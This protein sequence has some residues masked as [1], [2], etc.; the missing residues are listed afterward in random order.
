MNPEERSYFNT[1]IDKLHEEIHKIA[2]KVAE[3][4]Q[5]KKDYDDNIESKFDAKKARRNMIFGIVG[6]ITAVVAIFIALII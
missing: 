1:K 3:I 6:S 4:T 5:W 2:L